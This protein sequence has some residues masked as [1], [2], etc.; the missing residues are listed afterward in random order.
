MENYLKKHL[1]ET[2]ELNE[3][4]TIWEYSEDV[5]EDVPND[6]WLQN[7]TSYIYKVGVLCAIDSNMCD[8]AHIVIGT[9]HD[10]DSE[11][12]IKGVFYFNEG[13]HDDM[14]RVIERAL[15]CLKHMHPAFEN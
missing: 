8:W 11:I 4:W 2:V 12:E 13:E 7:N 15:F 1:K 6:E 14:G 3:E 10:V 5:N 9:Q